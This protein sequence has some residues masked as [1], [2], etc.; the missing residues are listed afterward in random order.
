MCRLT[1]IDG[2]ENEGVE[3]CGL[4]IGHGGVF[5][6]YCGKWTAELVGLT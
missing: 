5:V 2:E 1:T 6:G 3:R 4:A